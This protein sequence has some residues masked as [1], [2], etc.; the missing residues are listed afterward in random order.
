MADAGEDED[1]RE[2]DPGEEEHDVHGGSLGGLGVW[3]TE[4]IVDRAMTVIARKRTAVLFFLCEW[5]GSLA[6]VPRSHLMHVAV[7]TASTAP[8]HRCR[9]PPR[10]GA[11]APQVLREGGQRRRRCGGRTLFATWAC[12]PLLTGPSG[13]GYL[14]VAG[15]SATPTVLD[16]FCAA[17]GLG[18]G[19]ATRI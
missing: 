4:A 17:P 10:G 8:R 12:E 15:G 5:I 9:R 19:P 16:G 18:G 14:M 11:V 2:E 7:V 1:G 6:R 13:G 3:T